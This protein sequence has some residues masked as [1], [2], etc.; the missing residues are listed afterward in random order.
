M[1][2][3]SVPTEPLA[4]NSSLNTTPED[5]VQNETFLES[6]SNIL[7][8]S[9]EFYSDKTE[10]QQSEVFYLIDSAWF[11][12]WLSYTNFTFPPNY[13]FPFTPSPNNNTEKCPEPGLIDNTNIIE[14]VINNT[15]YL[16]NPGEDWSKDTRPFNILKPELKAGRDYAIVPSAVWKVLSKKFGVVGGVNGSI[17]RRYSKTTG[18][19][20]AYP[21][22]LHVKIYGNPLMSINIA[23]ASKGL[24]ISRVKENITRLFVPSSSRDSDKAAAATQMRLWVA[25]DEGHERLIA[26]EKL[27]VEH[28]LTAVPDS[29][30][31][32]MGVVEPIVLVLE[33]K[34][35]GGKWLKTRQ[36][37]TSYSLFSGITTLFGMLGNGSTDGYENEE[38]RTMDVKA[39]PGVCGLRN[40]GC[41]CFMNSALQCLSNTV[42]LNEYFVSGKFHADV[43]VHNNLGTQ[44]KLTEDFGAL[45]CAMWSGGYDFVSPAPFK[46]TLGKWVSQFKGYDQQD[47]QELMATLL[48]KLHEDLNAGEHLNNNSNS[49]EKKEEEKDIVKAGESAWKAYVNKNKSMIVDLF[50]GQL[51]SSL[52]CPECGTVSTTF[53]PFLSLSLPLVDEKSTTIK[54]VYVSYEENDT[55]KLNQS[56]VYYGVKL[57]GRDAKVGDLKAKM[58]DLVGIENVSDL[59]IGSMFNVD[60]RVINKFFKDNEKVALLRG[61]VFC[62]RVPNIHKDD[63]EDESKSEIEKAEIKNDASGNEDENKEKEEKSE[64]DNDNKDEDMNLSNDIEVGKEVEERNTNKS[65]DENNNDSINDKTEK[66]KNDTKEENKEDNENE[67]REKKEETVEEEKE[68]AK[69]DNEV[70]LKPTGTEEVEEKKKVRKNGTITHFTCKIGANSFGVPVI[71]RYTGEKIAGSVLYK[72]VWDALGYKFELGKENFKKKHPELNKEETQEN[73]TEDSSENINNENDECKEPSDKKIKQDDTIN[74]KD[75]EEMNNENTK[76]EKDTKDKDENNK[77]NKN[78]N[79]TSST[80]DITKIEHK[81]TGTY[82]FILTYQSQK[83]SIESISPDEEIELTTDSFF[84]CIDWCIECFKQIEITT[85]SAVTIHKTASE[86]LSKEQGGLTLDE[87]MD[88]FLAR[89]QL[90]KGDSWTCPHCKEPRQAFKKMDIWRLPRILVV[91]LK[92]FHSCSRW[93]QEKISTNV[94]FDVNLWDV[95]K[96]LCAQRNEVSGKYRLFA[97]SNHYG[98]LNGGHYTAFAKNKLDG[99]WYLF[100]DSK[101]TKVEEED[102]KTNSAYMLFY[103]RIDL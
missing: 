80:E 84:I 52:T 79:D 4:I 3:N 96:H 68:A 38:F 102:I 66:D 60:I 34:N 18:A 26:N 39:V 63:E 32:S 30:T 93:M 59:M 22:I 57:P 76:E 35:P 98:T 5:K 29:N 8:S 53:D 17:E 14:A 90:D 48:D 37:K 74:E 12:A 41:T 24:P 13:C 54:C 42:P 9:F 88:L 36:K 16:L 77:E 71:R 11:N 25:G 50:H 19:I 69:K 61:T 73:I 97:V 23:A 103:E 91:H 6:P 20:D 99:N 21:V 101:C 40:L 15:H 58:A 64:K 92:R 10:I 75:K 70:E 78:E 2:S 65:E 31:T 33:Q 27:C 100:N 62:Y 67:N 82:P 45:L 56:S 83:G 87:C 28:M 55:D 72:D 86:I 81:H 94:K 89:E 51:K 1:T 49:T 43:R 7:L 95:S 46:D 44:G 47:S 85:F